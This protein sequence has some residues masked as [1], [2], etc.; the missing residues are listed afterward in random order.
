M[1]NIALTQQEA[2]ASGELFEGMAAVYS[3]LS[4]TPLAALTPEEAAVLT[5]LRDVL[6]RLRSARP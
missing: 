1:D 3:R 5:D 6:T 2:G 4:A